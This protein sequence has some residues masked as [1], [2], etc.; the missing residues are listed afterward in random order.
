MTVELTLP[1]AAFGKCCSPSNDRNAATSP[2][3]CSRQVVEGQTTLGDRRLFGLCESR[4]TRQDAYQGV[5]FAK[6]LGPCRKKAAPEDAT[7]FIVT[8]VH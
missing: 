6:Q 8:N 2:K 4:P 5:A 3:E 1:K 7:F